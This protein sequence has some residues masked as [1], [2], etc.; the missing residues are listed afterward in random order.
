MISVAVAEVS[1]VAE[2][3]RRVA[4]AA[5]AL[6]FNETA[7]G[8]A[9]IVAT[10]LATNIVKYG[11]PGE[12]LVGSYEDDTGSGL[13]ILALDRGPGM[14]NTAE[15]QRDGHSTG[16]SAGIGLGAVKRQAQAFDIA[17]WPGRGTVVMARMAA[18]PA[19]QASI[20]TTTPFHAAV[21]V[22]LRGESVSGDIHDILR[23]PGGWTVLLAD[24]LGHGPHA[25]EAAHAALVIFR[26]HAGQAPVA[27]LAAIH[28]GLGHTR[29]G[30]VS[31][32]R[33][34]LEEQMAEF[35][36]IGNVAGAVVEGARTTRMVSLAGTAGHVARKIRSFTYPFASGSLLLMHSDGIGTSWSFDRYPG[37]AYAHPSLVAAVIYRDFARVRDDATVLVARAPSS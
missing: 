16:G 9:S 1:Q 13:E 6:G 29:G 18:N 20:E 4:G 2:A 19:G 8:R 5:A 35:A 7:S 28:A 21:A 11:G 10:E 33:I 36:G 34:D 23:D 15:A 25:A 30:A 22:P 12:I 24:G 26:R 32:C 31:I 37:L 17:S 14:S 27:V 3:R